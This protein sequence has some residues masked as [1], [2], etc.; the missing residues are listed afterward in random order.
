MA[1]P[2]NQ[3]IKNLQGAVGALRDDRNFRFLLRH[4]LKRQGLME[5][6]GVGINPFNVNALTQAHY[7]GKMAAAQEFVGILTEF[8]P[9]FYATLLLEEINAIGSAHD[10]A[11]RRDTRDDSF[12]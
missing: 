7:S 5:G 6:R 1:R 12:E 3:E 8:V 2:E 11:P 9:E 4:W 10:N